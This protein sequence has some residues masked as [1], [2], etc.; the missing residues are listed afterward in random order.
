MY[1]IVRVVVLL[2]VALLLLVPA[3]FV[4]SAPLT[5]PRDS[6]F[7]INSHIASRYPNPSSMNVP[8]DI[9]TQLGVGW[10]RED[11]QFH[12]IEPNR[13]EYDWM[14]HDNAI[15]E[16]VGH[17]VQIIGVLNG[18][19]PAWAT[20]GNPGDA[21]YPPDPTAFA[22]FATAVVSRYKDRVHY[23]EVWNE[24][25]NGIY[26]SPTPSPEAYTQ[27]LIQTS[28]A[29]KSAD[30]SA[31]VL[32]GGVVTP[33][34][35]SGFL[36]TIANN[37]GWNSFDIIS[38]HPY[39][40][41]KGPEEGDIANVGYES[42]KSLVE[43]LGYKPI[44]VTEFGWST[45]HGGR[46]GVAFSESDQASY[47]VRGA[48]LLRAAG[49]ER[50]MPYKL[51]D[52]ED[53]AKRGELYGVMRLGGGDDDYTQ[54]KPAFTAY[55][56]LNEQLAGTTPV[57]MID[58]LG[59][60][61]VVFDFE[62]TGSWRRG[63][64]P[65]GTLNHAGGQGRNGSSGGQLSYNFPSGGN[66]YVVFHPP[67]TVTIPAGASKLGIWVKGD[68]SGHA[69][70]A[71]LT[72]ANGEVLQFRLGVIGGDWDFLPVPLN[73]PVAQHDHI[74]GGGDL[75]LD[76]PATLDAIVLDD[77]PDSF[78]GSG[79]IFLDDMTA[80]SGPEAYG[81]RFTKGG[82]TIDVLWAPQVATLPVGT[83]S[84]QATLVDSWGASSIVSASN[85][86]FSLTLGPDPVYLSHVPDDQS[87]STMQPVPTQTVPNVPRTTPTPQLQPVEPT[88]VPVTG[89]EECFDAT[90]FCMS[91][92][93][94]EY[95]HQNGG[96]PVF[97]YPIGPQKSEVIEGQTF[98]VQWFER[99]RLELHPE[100]A[101]PY[102]VLLGRLSE[103]LLYA[104]DRI[105]QEN[106]KS[107]PQSGCRYFSETG[108]NV[109]GEILAAWR[110]NGLELDGIA[111]KTEDESLA[112][113]GLPLGE[114]SMETIEGSSYLVQWFER[115]RFEVHPENEPPF[116]V[117]FG[118]LGNEA[119]N[120]K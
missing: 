50:I 3:T 103:D 48:V 63:D 62:G 107:S 25:D 26:W 40:D 83:K 22:E 5:A 31:K 110:A 1:Q 58:D 85:G 102:D 114:A 80:V 37:G 98:Q 38:I 36:E 79:I 35:G 76:L 111:G 54:P 99:N 14:F 64:Q 118:L 53:S 71:W 30:S 51:K 2:A 81:A 75:R 16:L 100:N 65:N 43:R 91:G 27:L 19:T 104:D 8:G 13:G 88:T 46:G 77:D 17:G 39:T 23:W 56:T 52:S 55:K 96:L 34:P 4:R 106:P 6:V 41:P 44:W 89:G 117:L 28:A 82:K 72:D 11:F 32:S 66:D 95:W 94:R 57:K 59:K 113:F 97:G 86:Q 70:K 9:V 87:S 101:R 67:T 61:D 108:Y 45:G 33:S 69:I 74:R 12:R 7:G 90:G 105:W 92:R 47:L 21:F 29:I 116:N 49:A 115:A 20:P 84:S 18:P 15:D 42:I 119:Q 10:V 112:L 93:I 24:P 73:V 68:N 78:S 109:C 60:S 120:I